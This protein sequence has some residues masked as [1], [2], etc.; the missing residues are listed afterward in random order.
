MRRCESVDAG[1]EVGGSGGRTAR[2]SGCQPQLGMT[3]GD[4]EVQPNAAMI[5]ST[6]Q[7][8]VVIALLC[9]QS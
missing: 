2:L 6:Y 4:Q 7:R 3:R 9:T 5:V 8:I 1:F